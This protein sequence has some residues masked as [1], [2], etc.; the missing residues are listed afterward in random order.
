MPFLPKGNTS[1]SSPEALLLSDAI[2]A[3]IQKV[4][5]QYTL[6]DGSLTAW[7]KCKCN[8][9]SFV[10]QHVPDFC[11]SDFGSCQIEAVIRLLAARPPRKHDGKPISQS[12]AK[13][14]IREFRQFIRWL[15]RSNEFVWRKPRDYEASPVRIRMLPEDHA[16]HPFPAH[17]YSIEDLRTLWEYGTS[18]ERCVMLLGLNCGFRMSDVATLTNDEVFLRQPHPHS[19]NLA[20]SQ[21]LR[22]ST[23]G[24]FTITVGR[25][26]NGRPQKF[27]LGANCELAQGKV[28]LLK[29]LWNFNL[30]ELAG[31]H[32]AW[33]DS[34]LELAKNIAAKRTS[35]LVTE[36]AR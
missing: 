36:E 17:T 8:Q 1:P 16:R 35:T 31:R 24:R 33:T 13:A 21:H 30:R 6:P 10:Q 19:E 11:L 5:E 29:E 7:G 3:Y 25:G 34:N 12:W 32:S 4:E 22:R 14:T 23:K 18:W 9:I 20:Y 26:V 15:D 27:Y 2:A 28:R